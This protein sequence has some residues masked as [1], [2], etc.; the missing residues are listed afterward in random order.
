ME[1]LFKKRYRIIKVEDV[2]II[3]QF[4][5]WLLDQ[6]TTRKVVWKAKSEDHVDF[7]VE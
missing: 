3:F 7:C 6:E 1:N 4:L 5:S 2:R